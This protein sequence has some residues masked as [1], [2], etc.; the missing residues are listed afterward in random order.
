M[1]GGVF[2]ALEQAQPLVNVA[3]GLAGNRSLSCVQQL[4]GLAQAKSRLG[5]TA[6][7][8]AIDSRIMIAR[9]S[10]IAGSKLS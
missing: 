5:I 9:N 6:N 10:V 4:T 2:R 1:S 7:Q 3:C 8:D